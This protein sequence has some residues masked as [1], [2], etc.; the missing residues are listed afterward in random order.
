M[1]T[2]VHPR[3]V[4]RPQ[5]SRIVGRAGWFL[6]LFSPEPIPPPKPQLDVATVGLYV[7]TVVVMIMLTMSIKAD[8]ASV[9]DDLNKNISAVKDDVNGLRLDLKSL[10]NKFDKLDVKHN[11]VKAKNAGLD[12]LVVQLQ[13]DVNI[14]LLGKRGFRRPRRRRRR[15]VSVCAP[16]SI[17]S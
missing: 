16:S 3:M 17:T 9:K 1:R 12:R 7:I 13:N 14:A 2:G 5:P 4:K 10:S 15:L 11:E 6:R 8:I